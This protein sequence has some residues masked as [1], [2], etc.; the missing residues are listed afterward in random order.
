[1]ILPEVKAGK[2]PWSGRLYIESHP[3][4]NVSG[5]ESIHCVGIRDQDD[6]RNSDPG[7][8]PVFQGSV[9]LLGQGT[10]AP[11]IV[12]IAGRIM[13]CEVRGS[14]SPVMQSR[15]HQRLGQ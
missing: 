5:S 8:V 9:T 13:D 14:V 1:M 10:Q 7:A 6:M 2:L 12:Q 15:I 11:G 3:I 4:H